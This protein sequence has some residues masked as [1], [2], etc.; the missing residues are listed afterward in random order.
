MPIMSLWCLEGQFYDPLAY[1]DLGSGFSFLP[2]LKFWHFLTRNGEKPGLFHRGTVLFRQKRADSVPETENV[3]KS[4][5]KM[6]RSR[7]F[8][9]ENGKW[10]ESLAP[11]GKKSSVV[12]DLT[13]LNGSVC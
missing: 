4:V 13:V 3:S 2:T 10:D 6:Q 7:N 1:G 8:W 9:P 5:P 11:K 12:F